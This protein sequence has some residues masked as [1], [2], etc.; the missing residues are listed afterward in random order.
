MTSSRL[1]GNIRKALIV[2]AARDLPEAWLRSR[3]D[4]GDRARS[5]GFGSPDG[6]ALPIEGSA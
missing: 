6:P 4:T 5:A 2:E 1:T 3:A